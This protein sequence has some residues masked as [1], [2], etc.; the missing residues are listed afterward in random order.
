ML[1]MKKFQTYTVYQGNTI[2]GYGNFDYLVVACHALISS[3][4]T[5][6]AQGADCAVVKDN[7]TDDIFVVI[8]TGMV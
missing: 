5:I 6:I 1:A 8:I 3:D 4:V 7:F 2:I